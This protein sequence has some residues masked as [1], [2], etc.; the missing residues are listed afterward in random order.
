MSCGQMGTDSG[1]YNSL[2]SLPPTTKTEIDIAGKV[3]EYG[4]QRH[5]TDSCV[6]YF[7][8]DCCSGDILFNN[9]SSFYVSDFCMP[10]TYISSGHFRVDSN[11][12]RLFFTGPC[13]STSWNEIYDIDTT[14]PKYFNKDTI[15]S[16]YNKTIVPF[17]CGQALLFKDLGSEDFYS[18]SRKSAIDLMTSLQA[19]DFL[20]RI[21]RLTK[22]A[23]NSAQPA[24]P[25][26]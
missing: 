7:E 15:Y 21:K 17:K 3:Y 6:F 16:P 12:V 18:P 22:T 5:F 26:K 14:Q 1:H 20:D 25:D 9:D 8:C 10:G 2:D 19:N 24:S 23:A 13:V 11:R 4:D